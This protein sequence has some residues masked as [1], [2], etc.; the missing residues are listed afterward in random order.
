MI[1]SH[2]FIL[3]LN[4]PTYRELSKISS[5]LSVIKLGM[6]LNKLIRNCIWIIWTIAKPLFSVLLRAPC[7]GAG[8]PAPCTGGPAPC[9]APV[10]LLLASVV[11]L[12]A[13]P[14][15]RL[16]APAVVLLL[17]P[18]VLLLTPVVRLLHWVSGSLPLRVS[19]SLLQ[20][21]KASR[22][23]SNYFSWASSSHQQSSAIISDYLCSTNFY[24]SFFCLF[25]PKV[26]KLNI[27]TIYKS[28]IINFQRIFL[29][30]YVH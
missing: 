28:I 22:L 6:V 16:L 25:F 1:G 18:V 26:E 8:G 19:G 7:A 2:F 29:W 30:W 3:I 12:L 9:E 5:F 21:S 15:V 17:A 23:L 10:L 20:L 24:N 13:P 11:R 14:V 4:S 27:S